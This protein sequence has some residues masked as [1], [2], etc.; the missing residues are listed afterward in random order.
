M[1][2]L[3]TR[4]ATF[5]FGTT[6]PPSPVRRPQP[7]PAEPPLL[8]LPP[9]VSS[10][11]FV[12]LEPKAV[13]SSSAPGDFAP[14]RLTD[15]DP[16]ID[17]FVLNVEMGGDIDDDGCVFAF[18]DEEDYEDESM[19]PKHVPLRDEGSGKMRTASAES[20]STLPGTPTLEG[21]VGSPTLRG[22]LLDIHQT[23]RARVH[24]RD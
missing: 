11:K 4:A 23:K 16:P 2:A 12:E 13:L 3:R 14:P 8:Q 17:D 21:F 18:E 19:T 5:D 1:P 7:A 22:I 24:S 9:R 6:A 15:L 10:A 20:G